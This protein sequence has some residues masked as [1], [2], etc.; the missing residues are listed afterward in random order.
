MML[1]SVKIVSI[2]L[3]TSAFIVGQDGIII[4]RCNL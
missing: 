4:Q 1:I 3:G 2:A